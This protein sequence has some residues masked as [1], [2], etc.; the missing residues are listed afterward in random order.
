MLDILYFPEPKH[1]AVTAEHY[2]VL[3]VQKLQ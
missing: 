1:S 3:L 2:T